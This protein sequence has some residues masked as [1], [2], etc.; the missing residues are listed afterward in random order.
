ML[1]NPFQLSIH[2]FAAFLSPGDVGLCIG[3]LGSKLFHPLLVVLNSVFVA[4]HFRFQFQPTLLCGTDLSIELSER[5]AQFLEGCFLLDN[6]G[7]MIFKIVANVF[8]LLAN[9]L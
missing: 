7:G 2:L 4:F 3:V 6:T 8:G 9:S 5:L 1:I